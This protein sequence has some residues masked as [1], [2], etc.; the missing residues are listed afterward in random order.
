MIKIKGLGLVDQVL[1][2]FLFKRLIILF[3]RATRGLIVEQGELMGL[4]DNA[5]V[6]SR[7]MP[8]R[9]FLWPDPKEAKLSQG[10][11]PWVSPFSVPTQTKDLVGTRLFCSAVH[12]IIYPLAPKSTGASGALLSALI[13][14]I[15]NDIISRR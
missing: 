12:S 11:S 13:S 6:R 1:L 10:V 15:G 9:H 14:F 5:V 8:A 7:L 4:W 2:M 3:A